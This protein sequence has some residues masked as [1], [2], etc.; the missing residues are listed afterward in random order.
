MNQNYNT[1]YKTYV[2]PSGTLNGIKCVNGTYGGLGSTTA[3]YYALEATADSIPNT[4]LSYG[5]I[6]GMNETDS[7]DSGLSFDVAWDIASKKPNHDKY[8]N[9]LFC[10]ASVR[11]SVG[12]SWFSAIS[13]YG[14]AKD[15]GLTPRSTGEGAA[16]GTSGT[17]TDIKT[18]WNTN[19]TL[20]P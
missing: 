15:G 14:K 16:F 3:D 2:C 20:V 19:G 11:A 9:I 1:D 18:P 7:P 10:D 8:G 13:Y 4:N 5:F 12:A 17:A 6:A